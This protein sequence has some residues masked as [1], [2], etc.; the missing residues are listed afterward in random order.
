MTARQVPGRFFFPLL[1]IAAI[2]LAPGQFA[3]FEM[4]FLPGPLTPYHGRFQRIFGIKGEDGWASIET[5][6]GIDCQA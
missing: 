3:P 2:P 1:Q 5:R 6:D 4:Y